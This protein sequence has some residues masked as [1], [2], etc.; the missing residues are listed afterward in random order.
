MPVSKPFHASS[1]QLAP[2]ERLLAVAH[3]MFYRRGLRGV[4]VDAIAEAANTNKMTL[5]RHFSSKD[6]LVAEWLGRIATA[7]QGEWQAIVERHPGQP[8]RQILSLIEMLATSDPQWDRGCPFA[9]AIVE[10]PDPG[11]PARAVVTQHKQ[12]QHEWLLH[13]CRELGVAQPEALADALFFT[14]EGAQICDHVA[15]AM[16]GR[17]RL[18]TVAHYILAA[19]GL[20]ETPDGL[21]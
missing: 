15:D 4:G 10:M 2:R 13:C 19:E 21:G 5:Y 3:D 9:N 18:T 6:D 17:A 7:A 11:H 20:L 12:A 1:E 8:L 14:I 16:E